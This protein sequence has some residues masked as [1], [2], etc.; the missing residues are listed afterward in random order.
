MNFLQQ[1][2][3]SREEWNNL[4]KPINNEKEKQILNMI[5]KGY[6]D[7]NI[8]LSF[9]HCLQY[10]LKIDNKFESITFNQILLPEWEKLTK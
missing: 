9:Y 10:F 7:I 6:H 2:K 3:Q 8:V 4:E 1:Q 5:N